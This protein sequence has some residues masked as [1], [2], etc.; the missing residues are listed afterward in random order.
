[1]YGTFSGKRGRAEALSKDD[2]EKYLRYNP[3]QSQFQDLTFKD[4]GDVDDWAR[5][6]VAVANQAGVL[7]QCFDVNPYAT[8]EEKRYL[9]PQQMMTR[10]EAVNILVKLYGAPSRSAVQ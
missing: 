4:A 10:A 2:I 3:A 7:E 6:W 5:K 1:M 8:E 9:H